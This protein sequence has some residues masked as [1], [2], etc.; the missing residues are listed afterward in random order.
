MASDLDLMEWLAT[1]PGHPATVRLRELAELRRMVGAQLVEA[2]SLKYEIDQAL[3]E[4][5]GRVADHLEDLRHH[6]DTTRPT[7]PSG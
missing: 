1:H 4:V 5:D 7:S 3:D 2:A 6:I